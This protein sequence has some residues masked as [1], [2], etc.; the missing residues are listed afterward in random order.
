MK[1]TL[2]RL[3]AEGVPV[4]AAVATAAT[5]PRRDNRTSTAAAAGDAAGAERGRGGGSGRKG[6]GGKGGGTDA[7]HAV[8]LHYIRPQC[9]GTL[10]TL[11][12]RLGVLGNEECVFV[13]HQEVE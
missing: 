4:R 8:S 2:F 5:G 11:R 6:D 9:H 10:Q 1:M 7:C 12:G 13:W 3:A